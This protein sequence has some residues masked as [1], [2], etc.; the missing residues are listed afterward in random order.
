MTYPDVRRNK[1][2]R[3]KG[4]HKCSPIV[5]DDK[6]SAKEETIPSAEELPVGS[7]RVLLVISVERTAVLEAMVACS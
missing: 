1:I 4:R 6:Q 2:G 5:E 3:R 7:I